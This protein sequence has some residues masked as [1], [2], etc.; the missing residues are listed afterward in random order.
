[1]KNLDS[2][3]ARFHVGQI[4]KEARADRGVFGAAGQRG[5]RVDFSSLEER[6]QES[7]VVSEMPGGREII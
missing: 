2:K 1:M 3:Q 7:V 5:T 4:K 6:V